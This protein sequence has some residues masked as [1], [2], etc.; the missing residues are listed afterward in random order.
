MSRCKVCAVEYEK[1]TSLQ[2]V[3]GI[4]CS[5]IHGRQ[6][7]IRKS[8]ARASKAKV[9]TKSTWAAEAQKAFNAFIRARDY[10]RPCP[11]CRRENDGRHQRHAMHY[12]SVKA[13]KQLRF[14]TL[15]VHAGCAQCNT[16]DA[17]NLLEYRI[18]LVNRIGQDRVDW[19]ECNNDL[20]KHD[21]AYYQRIKAL[22][23][24]R[25]KIY[26]RFRGIT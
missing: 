19:L 8:Q 7:A 5:I 9:K 23:N 18:G 25:T 3:C 2:Q 15:N 20:A 12:R 13:A 17:G 24:K 11:A 26:K 6:R 10:N 4:K 22:Y 1:R 14:N 21:I 16:F